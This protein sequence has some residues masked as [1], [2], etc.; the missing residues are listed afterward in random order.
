MSFIALCDWCWE[1]DPFVAPWPNQSDR[2]N[3]IV[4]RV[5]DRHGI[6]DEGIIENIVDNLCDP[7]EK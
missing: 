4:R 3:V 1:R 2:C 7:T 6:T 5:L